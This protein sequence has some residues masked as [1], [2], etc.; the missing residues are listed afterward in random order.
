M[1]NSNRN[2]F[3]VFWY[4]FTENLYEIINSLEDI[5]KNGVDLLRKLYGE[6]YKSKYRLDRPLKKGELSKL[7]AIIG[8]IEAIIDEMIVKKITDLKYVS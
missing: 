5:E 7:R 8:R 1:D 2:Y 6:D 3:H 4:S